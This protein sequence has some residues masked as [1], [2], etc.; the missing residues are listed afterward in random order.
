MSLPA[1]ATAA[2]ALKGFRWW[3][4][5]EAVAG[6]DWRDH[7]PRERGRYQ[8]YLAGVMVS[9]STFGPVAGGYLTQAFGWPSIF[10]VNIPLGLGAVLLVL[11]LEARPGDRRRTTFDAP[12]LVLFILFA[13][14]VIFALAQVQRMT[15]GSLPEILG[16]L[17]L[18]TVSLLLL[19]WQEG[20]SASPGSFRRRRYEPPVRRVLCAGLPAA[21]S[22]WWI[23]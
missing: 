6:A 12:G 22:C 23:S 14:P 11:R 1:T 21:P 16:L 20:H 2:R 10:L 17:A 19:I 4:G 5:D 7:S 9:S 18:G 3:W 15:A 8:G 13:S